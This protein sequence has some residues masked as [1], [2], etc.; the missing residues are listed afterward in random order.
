[1]GYSVGAERVLDRL[2]PLGSSTR[3]WPGL[4]L[5][6]W[7]GE[8]PDRIVLLRPYRSLVC[9]KLDYGCLVYGSARQWVP[10]IRST[11]KVCRRRIVLRAFPTISDQS[12]YVKAIDPSTRPT[13]SP[14]STNQRRKML[15]F[16]ARIF[17]VSHAAITNNGSAHTDWHTPSIAF[18]H[19]EG[20]MS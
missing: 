3:P 19:L 17:L 18:R 12:L 1:M 8:P 4:L 6:G 9:S 11:I 10:R 13:R 7:I 2:R 5:D 16:L 20:R 15:L 14:N